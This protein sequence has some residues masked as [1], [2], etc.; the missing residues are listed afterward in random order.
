MARLIALIALVYNRWT[1]Y[2]RL[3][4]PN[5]HHEDDPLLVAERRG[6]TNAP[7]WT[8]A[9][10]RHFKPREQVKS[11]LEGIAKFF[12]WLKQIAG[13]LTQPERRALILIISYALQKFLRG[14][15]LQPPL[16]PA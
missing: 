9:P 14:R 1:L 2:V 3:A 5:H 16:L 6:A 11:A 7:R 13:Q 10:D 12:G 15:K 8:G 4:D